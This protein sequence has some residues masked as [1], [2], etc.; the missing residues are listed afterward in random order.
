L[1]EFRRRADGRVLR[2]GHRGAAALAPENTLRSF[3]RA[4]ALGVDF[5]E[6]DVLDLSDGTLVLAHSDDLREVSHGAAAGRVRP[7]SHAELRELAPELPTLEQAL[8][9]FR[10]HEAGLHVDVKCRAHGRVLAEALRRH[11]LVARSVVS[12]F[13]PETLREMRRAEATLAVALTYPEDRYGLARRRPLAPLVPPA[14]K[15]LGRALPL[16]LPRWVDVLGAA[17]AML[18]HAVVS[19]AAIERCHAHGAAVWAWTVNDERLLERVVSLG[20]DG[21]ISDDPRIFGARLTA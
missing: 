13:W 7:L 3:E 1:I 4:L 18:H 16:R 12:S 5:V 2:I 9:F 15:L 20:V 8:E 21:V 11:A 14:V 19:R 10:G 17:A 6:F